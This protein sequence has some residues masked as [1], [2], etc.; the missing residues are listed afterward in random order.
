MVDYIIIGAGYAGLSAAALSAKNKFSTLLLE[1]HSKIGGCASFYRRKGF[2]F[3]VG[4]TT[5]S[6]VKPNQPLGRLFNELPIEPKLKKVDPGL[7]VKIDG[8]EIIRYADKLKWAEAASEY[9]NSSKQFN[10]WQKIFEMDELAWEFLSQ[11]NSIPPNKLIDYIK[12]SKPTNLRYIKLLNGIFTGIQKEISRLKLTDEMFT[13]FLAEQLLI[14]TQNYADNSPLLTSAMGLAYPSETYYPYGGMYKPAELILNSFKSNG[15]E[16]K[17]KRKVTSIKKHKDYYKVETANGENFDAKGIISSI[18]I[19]NMV[20]LTDGE[21][22]KYYQNYAKY[23]DFAWGAYTINFAIETKAE[24]N[25]LYY[26]IHTDD[27]I[28]NCDACSYFV[29]FSA[30]D[31]YAKAPDGWRTVTISCHT[32]TEKWLNLTKEEYIRRKSVT[33]QY[34]LKS[35]FDN[36]PQ[37]EGSQIEWELAG[38]PKTFQHYTQRKNGFVGGIPHSIEKNLLKMPPN[39]TP[40]KN[41]YQIGDTAFPGQGTPGV[42]LGAFSCVDRIQN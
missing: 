13:K 20:E 32:K 33:A 6:G 18:P 2:T 29:S 42:V 17:F 11:N 7:I 27:Q 3:D 9:F 31:D 25:S 19:W 35:L 8:K 21:I 5:F 30:K 22:Q 38:S 14:T 26:Q 15:G 16:I 28:P 36:L 41:F 37:L 34:I 39:Q 4:A 1:S 24:L 10:F 40:F 12:L 23:F